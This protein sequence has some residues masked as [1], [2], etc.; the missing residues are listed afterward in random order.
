MRRMYLYSLVMLIGIYT[1]MNVYYNVCSVCPTGKERFIRLAFCRCKKDVLV[2]AA[3]L[4]CDLILELK[5]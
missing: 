3:N 5:Q 4:I 1:L 2:K